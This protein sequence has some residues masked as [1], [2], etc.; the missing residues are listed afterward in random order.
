MTDHCKNIE[1]SKKALSRYQENSDWYTL[2]V[3]E[4]QEGDFLSLSPTPWYGD[5][6]TKRGYDRAKQNK[7][8]EYLEE[9]K[10]LLFPSSEKDEFEL[11]W[12]KIS[13]KPID[14]KIHAVF[15]SQLKKTNDLNDRINFSKSE[16]ETLVR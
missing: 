12:K 1:K 15:E 3:V 8:L 9:H 16:T 10:E 6:E 4:D 5:L 14:T 13:K 7:V 2:K 11:L